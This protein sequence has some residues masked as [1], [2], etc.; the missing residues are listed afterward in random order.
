MCCHSLKIM[1]IAAILDLKIFTV[2]I[3]NY[4]SYE[5]VSGYFQNAFFPLY[6]KSYEKFTFQCRPFWITNCCPH[7]QI[8]VLVVLKSTYQN[9]PVNQCHAFTINLN[10]PKLHVL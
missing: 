9:Y 6:V 10:N 8:W 3:F 7:W 1:N 2:V 4:P 5:C